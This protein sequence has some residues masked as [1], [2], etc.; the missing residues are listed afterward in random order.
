MAFDPHREPVAPCEA[1]AVILLRARAGT[2]EAELFLLRRHRKASFMSSAYVFP[3]GTVDGADPDVR[4]TAARELFEEAGVLLTDARV[5]PGRLGQ[6]RA[7][8]AAAPG[9]FA[10]HIAAAELA[11]AVD[12]LHYFAHWITPSAESKRFSARFFLAELPNG[13]TPA[14]D[15]RETVDEIWVTPAEA[16]ARAGEL[17]LPPPQIRTM[18]DLQATAGAGPA[19]VIAAARERARHAHPILPRFAPLAGAPGGFALLLPWDP[20]YDVLGTGE[21]V[22]MPQDHPLATGPSRFVFEDKTW[23]HIGAPSSAAT[24]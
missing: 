1:A 18:Y 24:D 7:Q 16:L 4:W 11:L 8:Q 6:L 9:R 14:F 15:N 20:D 12:S 3:G 10:D 19:A 23:K 22:P 13:Q 5:A 17:R 21:A 2:G